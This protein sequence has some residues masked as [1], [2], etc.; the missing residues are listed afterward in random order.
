DDVRCLLPIWGRLSARLEK[1]GRSEWAREEFARLAANST[2]A[3]SGVLSAAEKWRKLR[4]LGALDR[5]RLAIVRDLYAWREQMAAPTNR[6]AG[7]VGAAAT[8]G[9]LPP[10]HPTQGGRPAPGRGPAKAGRGGV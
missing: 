3:D 4:G 9:E 2:P 10:P 6:R 1:L 5:R 8:A 7:G